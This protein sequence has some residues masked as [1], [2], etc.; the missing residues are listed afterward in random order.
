ML[1]CVAAR[2]FLAAGVTGDALVEALRPTFVRSGADLARALREAQ[3]APRDIGRALRRSVTGDP[4]RAARALKSAAFAAEEVPDV[5]EALIETY[6]RE[7]RPGERF[8][9]TARRLG[10]P[11]FRQAD[12]AVRRSTA[13]PVENAA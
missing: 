3:L 10:V 6:Q 7:R 4:A 2:A 1:R 5:V 9:D 13:Q 8:I 11:P 12:N